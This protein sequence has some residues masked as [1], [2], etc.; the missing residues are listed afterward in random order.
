MPDKNAVNELAK[1]GRKVLED[2]MFNLIGETGSSAYPTR[3]I[4][5]ATGVR[6]SSGHSFN[7]GE[8]VKEKHGILVCPVCG[9]TLGR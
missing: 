3:S 9:R 1:E 5:A 4:R 8:M 6:C 2:P 7:E